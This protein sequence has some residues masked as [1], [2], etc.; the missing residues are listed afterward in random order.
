MH[1]CIDKLLHFLQTLPES[2]SDCRMKKKGLV[3]TVQVGLWLINI[4][5]ELIEH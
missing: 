2:F 3:K 4:K 1:F 5:L